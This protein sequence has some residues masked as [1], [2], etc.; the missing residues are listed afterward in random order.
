MPSQ[1][2]P[3]WLTGLR[4]QMVSVRRQVQFL[5]SLSGLRIWHCHKLWHRSK[6]QHYCGCGIGQQLQPQFS[7]QLGKFH[8]LQEQPKEGRKL[9]ER[10]RK[11][12]PVKSSPVLESQY[13]N[14]L[15]QWSSNSNTGKTHLGP[16]HGLFTFIEPQ[17][18]FFHAQLGFVEHR[19]KLPFSLRH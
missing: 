18:G 6:I 15:K 11:K 19:S 5:A 10:E 14:P 13:S 2:L 16:Y 8:M 7:P 17:R 1:E 9:K 3:L 4:T 12:S